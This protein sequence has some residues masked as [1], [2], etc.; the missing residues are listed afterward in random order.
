MRRREFVAAL[1]LVGL[2]PLAVR[3][4]Q[5]SKGP[6][7]GLLGSESPEPWKDRLNAF[8]QGLGEAGY[9]EGQNVAIEYRWA[10]GRNDRL[11]ALAADLVNQQVS[12]IVVLGSTPS[13][14]AA[15]QATSII[16]I[17]FRIGT[18]PVEVGLVTSLARPGGNMTGVTTLGAMVAPKQL[19][20]LRDLVPG[21]TEFGLLLNPSNPVITN[22]ESRVVPAA[23]QALG[24]KVHILKATTPDELDQAFASL[25]ERRI[26][27]LVI[28]VDTFFVA[29]SEQ[30]A[31]LALRNTIIAV[32]PYE[33][34]AAAGGL[35]SYGGSITDAS[36]KAGVCTAR[37]LKG[38]KPADIPIEQSTYLQLVINAKVAAAL[39]L[40]LPSHLLAR[41]DKVID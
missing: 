33:E 20:L 40:N 32:S 28:A 25:A 1:G 12:V 26:R 6:L 5:P 10:E 9:T 34:F 14:I 38:E 2:A 15:K 16:P 22:I 19:E 41:A 29:R 36:R 24:L 17:V 39:G 8:R 3:A 18:D 21:A 37:V 13:A 23:A 11:P 31:A 27:G 30:L 7:I 35:I 4:Q